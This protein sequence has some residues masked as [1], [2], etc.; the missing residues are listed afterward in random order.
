MRKHTK[1]KVVHIIH[2]A[3]RT[4]ADEAQATAL[5]LMGYQALDLLIKGHGRREDF[6]CL[7]TVINVTTV[8]AEHGKGKEYLDICKAGL[9]AL[10]RMGERAAKS[11]KYGL[12]GDGYQVIKDCLD[13]NS[14]QIDIAT[15]LAIKEA[16][17]EVERRVN[18]KGVC[19]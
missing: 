17:L 2:P 12:D 8:L 9:D 5:K 15:K 18:K 7:A 13:L 6:D 1:R 14:Q 10:R 19:A 3:M 16:I 11:G 4:S